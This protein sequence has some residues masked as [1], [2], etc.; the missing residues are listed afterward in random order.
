MVDSRYSSI[1]GS[2]VALETVLSPSR[3]GEANQCCNLLNRVF[4][5]FRKRRFFSSL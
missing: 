2:T 3:K 1:E 4:F 5:L